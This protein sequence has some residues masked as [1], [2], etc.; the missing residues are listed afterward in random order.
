MCGDLNLIKFEDNPVQFCQVKSVVP[1]LACGDRLLRIMKDNA[2]LYSVEVP[3]VPTC[4][5]LFYEDGGETGDL[6]LY[7]TNDGI[8]GLLQLSRY[9]Q[10]QLLLL[11]SWYK[12]RF[13]YN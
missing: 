7:G 1:V 4:L 5:H 3:S 10:S 13:V 8:I 6:V 9:T 2:I 11:Q 12:L